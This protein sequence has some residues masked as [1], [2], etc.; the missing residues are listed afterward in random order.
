MLPELNT[1]AYDYLIFSSVFICFWNIVWNEIYIYLRH[2]LF[3][4]L[5]PCEWPETKFWELP[6]HLQCTHELSVVNIKNVHFSS[7]YISCYFLWCST[8]LYTIWIDIFYIKI[9]WIQLCLIS[10]YENE[11]AT[12]WEWHLLPVSCKLTSSWIV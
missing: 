5:G 7:I 2:D 10:C 3:H 8:V 4:N 12:G 11:I 1:C 6:I 9:S